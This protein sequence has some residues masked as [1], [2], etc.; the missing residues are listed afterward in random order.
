MAVSLKYL[1]IFASVMFQ[2]ADIALPSRMQMLISLINTH[3]GQRV[4]ELAAFEEGRMETHKYVELEL[5]S[6]NGCGDNPAHLRHRHQPTKQWLQPSLPRLCQ[7]LRAGGR[8]MRIG[9]TLICDTDIIAVDQNISS[10]F[11]PKPLPK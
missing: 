4:E 9:Q 1:R 8:V 5:F 11:R 2:F 6:S 10:P 3:H 7:Q